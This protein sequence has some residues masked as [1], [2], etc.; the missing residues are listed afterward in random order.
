MRIWPT[1][2]QL[3][4]M[5]TIWMAACLSHVPEARVSSHGKSW[6]SQHSRQHIGQINVA[7]SSRRA[8]EI[9]K[10]S[11]SLQGHSA[12]AQSCYSIIVSHLLPPPI[13]SPRGFLGS[14]QSDPVSPRRQRARS[15]PTPTVMYLRG[16]M[17]RGQ[18]KMARWNV[19]PKCMKTVC[20]T[21]GM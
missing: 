1:R 5:L 13:T 20:N 18:S 11:R 7:A 6:V 4:L 21:G 8:L 16:W 19:C 10:W 12:S 15:M 9:A 14:V 2:K 17:G 3:G